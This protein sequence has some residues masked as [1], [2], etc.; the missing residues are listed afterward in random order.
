IK[1]IAMLSRRGIGPFARCAL[2]GFG[3]GQAYEHRAPRRVVNVAHHPVVALAPS[4]GQVFAAHGLGLPAETM[5][6]F[7]CIAGH[8]AA[9]RSAMRSIG[10][11][12]RSLAMIAGPEASVGTNRRNFH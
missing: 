11:R 5:C 10:K 6:E 8:Y 4:G 1:E 7:G 9:S 3:T 12:S 2:A